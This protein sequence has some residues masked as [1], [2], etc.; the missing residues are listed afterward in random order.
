[1]H[2][3]PTDEFHPFEE[4]E[5]SMYPFMPKWMSRSYQHRC[6]QTRGNKLIQAHKNDFTSLI[7]QSN[8]TDAQTHSHMPSAELAGMAV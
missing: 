6:T 1:M 5:K 7:T 3:Y 2:L 4:K 8:L